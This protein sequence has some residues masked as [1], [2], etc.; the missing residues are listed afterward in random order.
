[1]R[2]GVDA[3]SIN[4]VAELVARS[5]RF[6]DRVFTQR[7]QR[8][9]KGKPQRWAS[10]WAAKEAVRKLSAASGEALPAFRDVEVVRDDAGGPRVRLRDADSP[11]ALS[12]T[13]DGGLAIA[14]AAASASEPRLSDPE[15]PLSLVL[16]QRPEDAHKGTFGRVLV[17]AVSC[18]ARRRRLGHPLRARGHLPDRRRRLP[19][20]DARSAAGQRLRRAAA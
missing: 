2:V 20:G 17:V 1:M 14:V 6:V 18:G 9:C 3:V 13:H 5:P 19:R 7:E 8:D 10:R 16:P 4:R 15:P 12:L 11:I